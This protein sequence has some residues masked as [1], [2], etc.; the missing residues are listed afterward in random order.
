MDA[1]NVG[2]CVHLSLTCLVPVSSSQWEETG[3]TLAATQEK[4]LVGGG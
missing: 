3:M 1:D 2:K 4:M